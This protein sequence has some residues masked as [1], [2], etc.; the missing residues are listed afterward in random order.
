MNDRSAS[1]PSASIL[2]NS[3]KRIRFDENDSSTT[4]RAP[5]ST[6]SANAGKVTPTAAAK[7]RIQATVETLPQEIQLMASKFATKSF[8]DYTKWFSLNKKIEDM[9]SNDDMIPG[10]L[11]FKPELRV[12]KELTES[13]GFKSLVDEF[14]VALLAAQKTLKPFMV[15][16]MKLN[17]THLHETVVKSVAEALPMLW[18]LLL[19]DV[20]AEGYGKHTL[21]ND[22]LT[23][24]GNEVAGL[25]GI[26]T[27]DF[28]AIYIETNELQNLP[29]S[30]AVSITNN[31]AAGAAANQVT[32][33]NGTIELMDEEEDEF[34]HI[35]QQ[36]EGG[37]PPQH[38]QQQ[39]TFTQPSQEEEHEA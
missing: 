31:A 21:V 11:Q 22:F 34:G 26:T 36:M 25:L 5:A 15:R 27:T 7:E 29:P 6:P 28:A 8:L 20:D 38:Q 23:I 16:A 35:V 9:E 12:I 37:V 17:A 1:S 30:N 19:A 10:S 3:G 18:E 4:T 39:P 33:Q 24:H 32:P 13:Q 14:D 2:H